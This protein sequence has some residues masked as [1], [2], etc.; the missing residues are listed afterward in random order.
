MALPT[1][2]SAC[3]PRQRRT[4][5]GRTLTPSRRRP[6]WYSSWRP[7]AS[8]PRTPGLSSDAATSRHVVRLLNGY[9]TYFGL[10]EAATAHLEA[11]RAALGLDRDQYILH[12]LFHRALDV[13]AKGPGF[14]AP[15]KE[16]K[17][18]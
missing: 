6:S 2:S 9:L 18:R 17:G 15:E 7:S 3:S 12:L 11:D 4:F 1:A 8:T 10:P 13:R 14:D 16:K 5:T